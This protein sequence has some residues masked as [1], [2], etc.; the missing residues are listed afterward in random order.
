MA[1]RLHVWIKDAEGVKKKGLGRVAPYVRLIVNEEKAK[2]LVATQFV[3]G[4]TECPLWNQYLQLPVVPPLGEPLVVTLCNHNSLSKKAVLGVLSVPTQLFRRGMAIGFKRWAL[5]GTRKVK[6]TFPVTA[7]IVMR[8]QIQYPQ[9]SVLPPNSLSRRI[10]SPFRTNA[11]PP[12]LLMSIEKAKDL[13]TK[14]PGSHSSK[15]FLEI[16]TST[17]K[18]QSPIGSLDGKATT[19]SVLWNANY[20]F[21]VSTRSIKV[22]VRSKGAL[23]STHTVGKF[24]LQLVAYNDGEAHSGW[25]HLYDKRGRAKGEIFLKAQMQFHSS[26]IIPPEASRSFL[27]DFGRE[28]F[29]SAS[30]QCLV[31]VMAESIQEDGEKSVDNMDIDMDVDADGRNLS[32]NNMQSI[33]DLSKEEHERLDK[34]EAREIAEALA[35]SQ[36]EAYGDYQNM[37]PN[38]LIRQ[39]SLMAAAM[40]EHES[41]YSSSP[42]SIS[43]Q[44]PSQS[45]DSPDQHGR[46]LEMALRSTKPSAPPSASLQDLMAWNNHDSEHVHAEAVAVPVPID[47]MHMHRHVHVHTHTHVGGMALPGMT[48]YHPEFISEYSQQHLIPLS[49][50]STHSNNKENGKDR[51]VLRVSSISSASSYECD[52]EGYDEYGSGSSSKVAIVVPPPIAPPPNAPPPPYIQSTQNTHS[53]RPN[54]SA[55]ASASA[56][57]LL[58]IGPPQRPP[59]STHTPTHSPVSS[60][61]HVSVS[62]SYEAQLKELGDMGFHDRDE[63]IRLLQKHGGNMENVVEALFA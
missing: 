33:L 11:P 18:L 47:G 26:V 60:P 39:D 4:N 35:Q 57:E 9:S 10:L 62:V 5:L 45:I 43:S 61:V 12:I 14:G 56:G 37:R 22:K 3:D 50:D 59:P 46:M 13:P 40:D 36:F 49:P 31:D 15:Y 2:T 27:G 44:S 41:Y 17:L 16:I 25:L 32:N 53:D 52:Y 42:S 29:L 6:G 23:G 24:D 38:A 58:D 21:P 20:W 48:G 7:H 28:L 30:A 19:K 54:T 1:Y 34:R 51:D 8:I 55:S 63:L